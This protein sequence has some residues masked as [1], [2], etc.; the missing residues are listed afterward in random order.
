MLTDSTSIV[1]ATTT[2]P[3]GWIEL[4][5][6]IEES[7][8]FRRAARS[9]R[10]WKAY[11]SDLRSFAGWADQHGVS[12]LPATPETV[13]AYI[14]TSASKYRPATIRRHLA[15][16]SVAHKL[17]GHESPTKHPVVNEVL[18]G[19]E[20][21]IGTSQT[22]KR[23]LTVQE[24]RRISR[25]LP[26][27]KRGARDR[28]ILLLGVSGALRR[29]EIVGLDVN[30][31]VFVEAGMVVTLRVSK[32]DQERAG[33]EI[34]VPYAAHELTCAVRVVKHWLEV[35]SITEGPVFRGVDRGDRVSDD[36]LSAN[37]VARLVKSAC[38]SIGLDVR[39]VGGHSLRASYATI[40]ASA[41]VSPFSLAE[42]GRWKSLDV[43]QRYV[44]HANLVKDNPV[45]SFGF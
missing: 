24:I 45:S 14:T 42:G 38:A 44:R 19:I 20:R 31:I 26:D 29:S 27:T 13:V 39:K 35:A 10:T 30:D 36:R 5:K 1:P 17:A 8:Q 43:L 21:T 16:I 4:H 2:A 6:L 12:A 11:R 23:A 15:A 37:G 18:K 41:G 9:E 32:S 25:K 3:T 33:V 40:G 34:G 28:A 22:R 7:E